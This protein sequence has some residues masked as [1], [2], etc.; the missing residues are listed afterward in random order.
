MFSAWEKGRS[1]NSTA[2][3]EMSKERIDTFN[4]ASLSGAQ[5]LLQEYRPEQVEGGG[6]EKGYPA[7]LKAFAWRAT[8]IYLWLRFLAGAILGRSILQSAEVAIFSQLT[9]FLSGIGF[10][11]VN[12]AYLPAVL[13]LGWFFVIT[14][15]SPGGMIGFCF[16]TIFLPIWVPIYYLFRDVADEARAE[17]KKS[18]KPGLRPKRSH[19]PL[20]SISL[21]ALIGWFAVYGASTTKL[22]IAPGVM[23][24]GVL[25]LVLAYRSFQ[26]AK[27]ITER[28]AAGLKSF[29]QMGL[30]FVKH[31]VEERLK[32]QEWPKKKG[33]VLL[34]L[35]FPRLVEWIYRQV[36][37]FLRGK[38]GR[39][40]ISMLVL[41]DYVVALLFLAASAIVFWALVMR[42]VVAPAE[43]PLSVCLQ[44]SASRFIPGLAPPNSVALPTWLAVGPSLTAWLLFLVYAGVS[45]SIL[46]QRQEAFA[47]RLN[48]TYRS[49]RFITLYY[50]RKVRLARMLLAELGKSAKSGLS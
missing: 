20:V 15:F 12:A 41:A 30:Q 3:S 25:F 16:Y 46:P 5:L 39:E 13:K 29:E 24:S 8:A 11:P 19:R 32:Q 36:A 28:D 17:T 7:R 4:A 33:D 34:Q 48:R 49:L 44:M 50:R 22:Q 1:S 26:R 38:K 10:E 31:D 37:L 35:K 2:M 21:A 14:G 42:F 6:K 47:N 23:F 18:E 40:R 45:A 43:I 27:P 9:G